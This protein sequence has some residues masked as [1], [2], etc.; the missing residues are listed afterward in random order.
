MNTLAHV[1]VVIVGGGWTGL[2]MAKEIATR[3]SQSVVVLERGG[4]ARTNDEWA[5]G[6][7]EVDA[8]IRKR[9]MH[10]IAESALTHR[11]STKSQT[12]PIRQIGGGGASY[13]SGVGGSGELWSAVVSRFLPEQFALATHLRQKYGADKLPAD[14]TIQDWGITYDE[15]EPYYWRAEQMLGVGGK[16]GN[17]R[18]KIV[19]GGNVFEG[20]RSHEYVNPPHPVPYFSAAFQKAAIELGYHPYPQPSA[21]LSRRYKN[22]DG[23]ER[24]AC[25]YCG[26]CGFFGCMVGAK[27]TPTTTMLPILKNKKNFTLRTNSCVRRIVHKDGK[28]AGVTYVDASGKEVMQP[29]DVVIVASWT[30]NNVQLLLLSG[31]GEPY[32]PDTGKGLV[33][34]N[35][36]QHVLH[37]MLVFF[38]KP[39]NNFMGAGG[40]GM[41]IAD[42]A[43][44]PPEPDVAAG[45]FRG[46]IIR[47]IQG[48]QTPIGGFGAIPAGEVT[49]NWGSDWKKAGLKWYDKSAALSLAAA[50]F[51]YKQNF[52][53]LDPVY[54]DK[55]GDP[56]VRMTLDWTD[57]D[58]REAAMIERVETSLAKAMGAKAYNS[59]K[60]VGEHY[61]LAQSTEPNTYGGAIQGTSPDS[62]VVNPWLQHWQI[63][64]LW[65]IG[66]SSFPQSEVQGTLTMLATTYR[67]ADAL[68][69]RYMKK[70]GALA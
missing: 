50:H 53:D 41:A 60:V 62:S 61:N 8:L 7:D 65:V 63:P 4:P 16:A 12:K 22:P 5:E 54:K 39:M 37:G 19:E 58:R 32:D 1:D 24:A 33:G 35:L 59:I 47:T 36:T 70:P 28:A 13:A 57:H 55:F 21:N 45:V 67:A 18:G 27:A 48:G 52:I 6:M 44:D 43:G 2:A 30:L 17:L 34:K 20:P 14:I 42:F 46:G 38:D 40:V 3:T 31:I 9:F 15:L 26:Y 64:N 56:L 69:D 66:G 25:E 11:H 49:S 10:N 29:A 68:V 23:V 51:S